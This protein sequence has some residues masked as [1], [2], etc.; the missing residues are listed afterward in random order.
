MMTHDGDGENRENGCNGD[1]HD[2]YGGGEN[3]SMRIMTHMV[4]AMVKIS[5]RMRMVIW[6]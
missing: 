4:M 3:M 1:N 5:M 6:L 2:E